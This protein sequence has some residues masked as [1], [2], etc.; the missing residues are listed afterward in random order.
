MARAPYLR[1]SDCLSQPAASSTISQGSWGG[2]DS[3]RSSYTHP[4]GWDGLLGKC[5]KPR[6]Q[7]D[8]PLLLCSLSF[9]CASQGCTVK[10]GGIQQGQIQ[11]SKMRGVSPQL[12]SS[13]TISPVLTEEAKLK[14]DSGNKS[15]CSSVLPRWGYVF[16]PGTGWV[17]SRKTCR[18]GC[19][20]NSKAVLL[21]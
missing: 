8:T 9:A 17:S 14:Q 18:N 20:A 4:R 15:C 5:P 16:F 19:Y 2:Q 1:H 13:P 7:E 12:R 3:N 6:Y 11:P 10:P 21:L